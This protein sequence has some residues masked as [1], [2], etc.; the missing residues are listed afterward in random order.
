MRRASISAAL[1]FLGTILFL[2]LKKSG[3]VFAMDEWYWGACELL[4]DVPIDARM[5]YGSK[6]KLKRFD[7]GQE[8]IAFG[9]EA[10]EV[11]FLARGSAD[12]VLVDVSGRMVNMRSVYEGRIFGELAALTGQ[13]RIS[14]VFARSPCVIV[15]LESP[16]FLELIAT[17]PS[18]AL[19]LAK[20]LANTIYELNDRM[21]QWATLS[22]KVRVAAEV[23]RLMQATP[24]VERRCVLNFPPTHEALA[25]AVASTREGVTRELRDLTKR[26][27]LVYS[28]AEWIVPDMIALRQYFAALINDR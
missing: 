4:R 26:G 9:E 3:K 14:S 11:C 13:P 5:R 12:A 1:A 6:L 17:V 25:A 27:L 15:F 28:R 22:L 23:L 8:I 21:Q 18:C 10:S 20:S 19:S 7:P 24:K 2:T 16:Q